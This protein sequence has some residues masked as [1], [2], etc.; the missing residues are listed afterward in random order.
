[1]TS[2]G[3]FHKKI[4]VIIPTYNRSGLIRETI[5]TILNQTL[6]PLEII[7]VDDGSTDDTGQV[8]TAYG[9]KVR[10]ARIENSGVC[11]AR[12]KGVSLA[13][14]DWIAFCD[15]DD[16]WRQDKLYHQVELIRRYPKI[17][18]C[19]TNFNIVKD[20]QWSDRTKFDDAPVGYWDVQKREV[21]DEAFIVDEPLYST[22]IKFQPIF[23]STL[24]MSK[25]FFYQV[26]GFNESFGRMHSEDFE[27]TLRCTQESPIGVINKPVVGIRWHALNYSQGKIPGISFGVSDIE[28]LEYSMKYHRMGPACSDLIAGSI[29]RRCIA[30]ADGAF[31]HG[32]FELF[33][34]I[35]KKI[36]KHARSMKLKTKAAVAKLPLPAAR[37][38]QA[39]L[40]RS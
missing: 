11:K 36:P 7:V 9:E 33:R 37:A 28:I 16:F 31:E 35:I 5:D 34:Q 18:Y 12:N 22:I 38:I 17:E 40:V 24:M 39:A 2:E 29:L 30:V 21:S 3:Q 13:K 23:P 14:G 26:G 32:D 15:H 25:D 8:V 6:P 27:F 20:G 4:S 19:F 10:Y 1:M